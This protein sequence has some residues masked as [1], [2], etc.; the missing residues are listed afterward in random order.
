MGE[1]KAVVN[2]KRRNEKNGQKNISQK[3]ERNEKEN[4]E[5]VKGLGGGNY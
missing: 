4:M 2:K 3:K 5:D 1:K